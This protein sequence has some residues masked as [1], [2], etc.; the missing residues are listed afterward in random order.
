LCVIRLDNT[1]IVLIR[2]HRIRCAFSSTILNPQLIFSFLIRRIARLTSLILRNQS[3]WQLISRLSASPRTSGKCFAFQLSFTF[4]VSFNS[5]DRVSSLY[6][7][8]TLF[9][10]HIPSHGQSQFECNSFNYHNDVPLR[11]HNSLPNNYYLHHH[12]PILFLASSRALA[13]PI[14]IEPFLSTLL[15]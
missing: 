12:F 9:A 6:F 13:I 3:F 14:K 4:G 1:L 2:L 10:I 15:V 11:S 8:F 7:D 5:F